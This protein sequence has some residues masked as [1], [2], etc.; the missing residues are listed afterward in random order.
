MYLIQ[1]EGHV[2]YRQMTQSEIDEMYK[3]YSVE[4]P[5]LHAGRVVVVKHRRPIEMQRTPQYIIEVWLGRSWYSVMMRKDK[6]SNYVYSGFPLYRTDDGLMFDSN[7]LTVGD[8]KGTVDIDHEIRINSTGRNVLKEHSRRILHLATDYTSFDQ[9]QVR[10]NNKYI[11]RKAII[12]AYKSLYGDSPIGPFPSIESVVD[13]IYPDKPAV[14]LLPNG[15]TIE[16]SGVR[17]GEYTTMAQNNGTNMAVCQAVA[18]WLNELKIGTISDLKIQGDDVI[19]EVNLYPDSVPMPDQVDSVIGNMLL[20]DIQGRSRECAMAVVVTK[21]VNL[22]GLETNPQKGSISYDCAE[23]L[24]VLIWRGREIPNNFPMVAGAEKVAM[25]DNPP[26]FLSGQLHKHDLAISRG[27]GHV[28]LYRFGLLLSLLRFSYRVRVFPARE[29]FTYYYYPP[30]TSFITPTIL[31]GLGRSP[32]PFPCDASPAMLMVMKMNKA[33]HD[34]IMA[35]CHCLQP[36]SAVDGARDIANKIMASTET[37]RKDFIVTS[38]MTA[39]NIPTKDLSRPFSAGISDASASLDVSVLHNSMDAFKRLRSRGVR[40]LSVEDTY[41]NS[42]RMMVRSVLSDNK[43]VMEFAAESRKDISAVTFIDKPAPKLDD[44]SKWIMSFNIVLHPIDCTPM[45]KDGPLCR[46]HPDLFSTVS[47]MPWG[48]SSREA[49]SNI[50]KILN[51]LKLDPIL[52]RHW[53]DE[54]LSRVIFCPE[55]F[56]DI[57]ILRDILAAIGVSSDTIIDIETMFNDRSALDAMLQF[58]SGAFSLNSPL[59]YGLDRSK[60]SLMRYIDDIGNTRISRQAYPAMYLIWSY[61]FIGGRQDV[62][63]IF[64]QSADSESILMKTGGSI[65]TLPYVPLL[66]HNRMYDEQRARFGY[67]PGGSRRFF[68][69]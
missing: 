27:F 46:L 51:I 69:S 24:K 13:I 41:S 10:N 67:E 35:R 22:C 16:L 9:T 66:E 37:S 36:P 61:F 18:Y 42:P 11:L 20:D 14:F 7:V 34:H 47:R 43:D 40:V 58:V 50:S 33:V 49:Q 26:G 52:P 65:N 64:E 55:V 4:H 31:N 25:A 28:V 30:W 44:A 12:D 60:A 53:T 57:N 1:E 19:A 5:G 29:G 15:E 54:G 23:Y 63:L 17:S 6:S 3:W 8:E 2:G 68:D 45:H 38:R 21:I 48:C 56:D 62:K 39:S 32:T 59:F